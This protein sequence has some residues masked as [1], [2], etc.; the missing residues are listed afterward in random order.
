MDLSRALRF[1]PG[2]A[3]ALVGSGGKTTALFRLARALPPP[4]MVAATAHLH[5]D[6][7]RQADAHYI[8][9]TPAEV[10]RLP[11]NP[12]G[13][14]LVT[15][16]L[17]GDRTMG[18]RPDTAAALKSFSAS[19]ALPLLIEADG[20]R[21]LPLKAPSDHEPPI[22]G[23]VDMV[24]VVAGLSG[25]GRPLTGDTVF[26]PEIFR[27]LSGCALGGIITSE[28]VS[29]EL[30]HPSGGLKNIPPDA[31]RSVLLNQADTPELQAQGQVLA[32]ILLPVYDSVI[33]ASLMQ[34]RI[35]S[36]FERTAGILLAAGQASR[37]GRPKQ[38]EAYNGR[39]FVRN[40]AEA[41]LSGGLSPVLV[42]TGAYGEQVEAALKGLAVEIVRNER[43][44]A[45]Q[46]SSIQAGL[47]SLPPGIG[48]TLFLLADQPQIRPS[49]IRSL[50]ERHARE[51][52]PIIAPLV[53]GQRGNPVLFDQDTFPD[54]LSL[55]GDSGGRAIFSRHP[56]DYLPWHD[57]SVLIDIDTAG[58]MEKLAD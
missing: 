52:A 20:S 29:H 49:L 37:F 1:R 8:C 55:Q 5:I 11:E 30:L 25:I 22:P 54:L 56:V 39:P 44:Q 16:P 2:T 57:E 28:A 46:S 21:R 13:V 51:L 9:A 47:R 41:A 31:R 50:V 26:R 14:T 53:N 45:G 6:Q 18:I 12:P 43:W 34:N 58:D 24:V 48:S 19:R 27:R 35:Y 32:R 3:A 10:A 40:V 42:V 15:G 36:T 17:E 23:F 7:V 38:L 33:I 4:V